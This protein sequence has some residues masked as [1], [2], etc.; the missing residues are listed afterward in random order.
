MAMKPAE[1]HIHCGGFNVRKNVRD[2]GE[3]R[4][5]PLF[6]IATEDFG[7]SAGHKHVPGSFIPTKS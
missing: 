7:G 1:R 3:N 2:L 6:P 5:I 4:T